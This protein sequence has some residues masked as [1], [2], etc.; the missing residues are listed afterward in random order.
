MERGDGPECFSV[1]PPFLKSSGL[2]VPGPRMCLRGPRLLFN[3]YQS[4]P[5]TLGVVSRNRGLYDFIGSWPQGNHVRVKPY[6]NK[7]TY[8]NYL[9]CSGWDGPLARYIKL[10]VAHALGILGRFPRHR[11]LAIPTCIMARAS[12]WRGKRSRHSRRMRDPQ[13]YVSGKKPMLSTHLIIKLIPHQRFGC[14]G[15]AGT[16]AEVFFDERSVC[17]VF[18]ETTAPGHRR[19]NDFITNHSQDVAGHCSMKTWK[20]MSMRL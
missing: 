7:C 17:A 4:C 13:F 10:R 6:W 3:R 19:F 16:I 14:C 5:Q 18:K 9:F 12:Q 2:P 1:T 8:Y 20:N 15:P 11:G